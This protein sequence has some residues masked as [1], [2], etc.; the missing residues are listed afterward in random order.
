[1]QITDPAP[2][3]DEVWD[4]SR[5]VTTGLR[6]FK[7][8]MGAALRLQKNVE[9]KVNL[10]VNQDRLRQNKKAIRIVVPALTSNSFNL[11][12]F[13]QEFEGIV[14][15]DYLFQLEQDAIRLYNGAAGTDIFSFGLHE[16]QLSRSQPRLPEFVEDDA[17]IERT[18]VATVKWRRVRVQDRPNSGNPNYVA[19]VL[20]AADL[21]P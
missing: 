8:K 17:T 2:I 18:G 14:Y 6:I 10:I 3:D 15:D 20:N 13:D 12:S 1:M 7:E 9:K 4:W 16:F 11:V 21:P 19:D 5:N